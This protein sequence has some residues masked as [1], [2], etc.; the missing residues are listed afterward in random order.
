MSLVVAPGQ[1]DSLRQFVALT[2]EVERFCR[3][4]V[5]L[6]GAPTPEVTAFRRWYV[7]EV[8]RQVAGGLPEPCPFPA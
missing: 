3:D 1:V 8:A 7:A 2:D 4:G 5:L 6:S